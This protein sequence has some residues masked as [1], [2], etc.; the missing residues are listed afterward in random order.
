VA[1]SLIAASARARGA[2]VVVRRTCIMERSH[3]ATTTLP[4]TETRNVVLTDELL[5]RCARRAPVYDRDNTFFEEDFAELKQ[6]GYL[7]L[8]VPKELGGGGL[9]LAEMARQTRRLAY[10]A[11]PTA[12]GL[13]MHIYWVGI[14]AD[15][16][17]SG[18]KS[19]EWILEAAMDGAVF[20]AG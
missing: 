10:Y 15:L 19:L 14:A 2:S 17:R 13:N 5:E 11:A 8:P 12:L 3:M 20:A 4:A 18:D 7:T 6:A 16:W 1:F 9:T